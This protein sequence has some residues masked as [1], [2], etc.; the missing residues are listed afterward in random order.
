[1]LT[2]SISCCNISKIL[3][4]IFRTMLSVNSD[5][6]PEHHWLTG[7]GV[8]RPWIRHRILC[9]IEN[10]LNFMPSQSEFL[11]VFLG[12]GAE[13][14][15]CPLPTPSLKDSPPNFIGNSSLFS[16]SNTKLSPDT[17]LLSSARY[18]DYPLLI[19]FSFEYPKL[20]F[21]SSLSFLEER[22][23]TAWEPSKQ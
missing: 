11:A 9:T 17:R 4:F 18:L 10:K 20:Y 21:T 19:I 14:C 12:P 3:R 1:M 5:Y 23:G 8:C 22:P 16:I 15:C 7:D 2:L 6:F 13:V